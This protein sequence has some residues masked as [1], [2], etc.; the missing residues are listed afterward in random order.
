MYIYAD[1]AATTKMSKTAIKAMQPYLEDIYANPSSLHSPGQKAAEELLKFREQIAGL[2]NAEPG[3]IYFTSGGS[4]ADNQA[5]LSAAAA[6]KKKG[7]THIVSTA[8]EHHA[9]L[10]TLKKLEKEGF[11][12]ETEDGFDALYGA[13]PL[14]RVIRAEVEDALAERLLEGELHSGDLARIRLDGEKI[15]IVREDRPAIPTG[16]AG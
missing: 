15:R 4:E 7:K 3:E 1:N 8:F 2:I 14:R 9:V 12:V 5:I 13:R 6:G 16:T 11:K 10:H